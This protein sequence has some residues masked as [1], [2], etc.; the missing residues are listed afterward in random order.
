MYFQQA[1]RTFT[2][3]PS[4]LHVSIA[5]DLGMAHRI[6]KRYGSQVLQ[7]HGTDGCT[8]ML[9]ACKHGHLAL[10]HV[11]LQHGARISDR[12]RDPK[13]Q[14]NTLHYAAWGGDLE[15]VRWLLELGAS[16][17]DVDIVGNTPL[18]YAVYGGH[19]HIIDEL[20]AR[21]R[22]LHERNL[23]NHTA[24]LQAACGGHL[25]IVKWLLL[26]GF[27]LSEADHDGNTALLFAA[28][29]GHL[30]LINFLLENGSS[31]SEQNHNGH[32]I[33]LS[34]AN[35]GRVKIVE[36]LLT[37]GF[38]LSE[39]NNNGDT[40]L[41]L[42]SYGGHLHLVERLLQLGAHLEDK[43]AC[44]FT[45]LLSAANGGQLEMTKWLL[46]HGSS[47]DEC[48]GDGYTS[49]IL[50]A[51]GGNIDLVEYLLTRGSNLNDRN[52]NGDSALLLA[53]YCSHRDLVDWLLHNGSCLSEK[54]KTGMGVLISAANGGDCETVELLLQRIAEAG[55]G[56]EDG[57]EHTDE[58]GYTPLLLAAQRGHF[59]VVKMLL[60]YGS[61]VTAR[62]SRHDNDVIALA[63]DFPD[64][65]DYLRTVWKWSPLQIAIDNRMV[66][67]V[68]VL[69]QAGVDPNHVESGPS[70]IELATTTNLGYRDAKAPNKEIISLLEH[71]QR[72]WSPSR[73]MLHSR[74][75]RRAVRSLIELQY[76]F[77][78]D[79][80]LAI[81]PPE[82]WLHIASFVMRS[83]FR[84][85][86]GSDRVDIGW[87]TPT[88]AER[89][90]RW[91]QSIVGQKPSFEVLP[92]SGMCSIETATDMDDDGDNGDNPDRSVAKATKCIPDLHSPESSESVDNDV[93]M[94]EEPQVFHAK[95]SDR[96]PDQDMVMIASK[97]PWL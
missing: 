79:T 66:D 87:I 6:L 59:D 72:E 52:N 91:R 58:G 21:G 20:L 19:K 54:N 30:D 55:P 28:W 45:P 32:S 22:T 97:L 49:L 71:A 16:L 81:V 95:S 15:I 67:R 41:L 34:A 86:T 27:S 75:H 35:G 11:Y 65:Q 94:A 17:D 48:D 8:P 39:T 44:G 43:N 82:I 42:A 12:D 96:E 18:L 23:K 76:Y 57:L 5:G 40:A 26:Q 83:W 51:C 77:K 60:A 10:A 3:E 61:N 29:G 64:V 7:V 62:T 89:R 56:C 46:D 14:G 36:W 73:H 38:S 84:V 68:H 47:L 13:R 25:E 85:P 9:L 37:K 4:I 90:L 70:L 69:L 31:L 88:S 78:R 93:E 24:L 53:A 2:T 92:D 50:A 1:R 80:S 74:D 33:F 63:V